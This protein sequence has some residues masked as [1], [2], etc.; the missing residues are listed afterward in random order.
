MTEEVFKAAESAGAAMPG[1]LGSLG[2]LTLNIE[3][4]PSGGGTS[5][6]PCGGC[7]NMICEARDC[8]LDI[9]ICENGQAVA[10]QC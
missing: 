5:N 7:H 8:G 1:A 3:W 9:K 10:P 6:Q 4:H 2:S